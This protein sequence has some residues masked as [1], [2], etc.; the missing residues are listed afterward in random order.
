MKNIFSP[1]N[2]SIKNIIILLV[3]IIFGIMS[4]FV[5]TQKN[6]TSIK[7]EKAGE[8]LKEANKAD[9]AIDPNKQIIE[10]AKTDIAKTVR[11]IDE[12]DHYQGNLSAP[13]Q[14]IIYDDFE[15]PFCATFAGIVK[16]VQ[17]EFGEKVVVAVRHYTLRSHSNALPAAVASECAAD[18]G[19]FWE[20]YDKLFAN[21]KD[22]KLSMEQYKLNAQEIGLETDKFD[23][24]LDNYQYKDKVSE[25]TQEARSFGVSGTPGGFVN[26]EPIP[27][28]YPFEDFV[29][30][31]N[32]P[33]EG[34]K[35]IIERHLQ[36][37][38]S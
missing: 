8:V 32:R 22:G 4:Y 21:N 14:L 12:S 34:M 1:E 6:Q 17:K 13:I 38:G 37:L 29:G 3:I 15:C 11:V 35:S 27:G 16:Q 18:Q 33:Q 30:S 28:A 26:G 24:C 36:I 10:Q 9:E 19:K 7:N 25:Q 31:D 23:K 2:K 20:M 5:F